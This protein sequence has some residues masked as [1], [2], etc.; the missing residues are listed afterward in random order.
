MKRIFQLVVIGFS[1]MFSALAQHPFFYAI[2]EQQGLP[3]REVYQLAQDS[4]GYLWIGTDAGLFRYDGKHFKPFKSAFQNSR[5][6]SNLIVAGDGKLWCQNFSGQIFTV[7]ADSLKLGID[8]SGKQTNYSIYNVSD[9]C[10]L[11]FTSDTGIY[12]LKNG[13]P[14]LASNLLEQKTNSRPCMFSDLKMIGSKIFFCESTML[15]YVDDGKIKLLNATNQPKRLQDVYR[16]TFI[17][18]INS[19]VILLA[20][21]EQV[22]SIWEVKNDS[23]LWL[24]DLPKSLG[25][26]FALH[27]DGKGKVWVGGSNGALCL[28]ENFEEV[29]GGQLFFQGVSISDVVVDREKNYWFSSLQEGIFVVPNLDVVVYTK[30]NSSL[31]DSRLKRLQA[32]ANHLF[33]GYQNG[34]LGKMNFKGDKIQHI[35]FSNSGVEIQE[36]SC[37]EDCAKLFIGQNNS[38]LLDAATMQEKRIPDDINLKSISHLS[39]D[40]FFL[41]SVNEGYIAKFSG[42][43]KR[44]ATLRVKRVRTSFYNNVKRELLVGYSDGVF[45]YAN[46]EERELQYKGKP[47]FATDMAQDADGAIWISTVNTG[48]VKYFQNDIVGQLN[49]EIG[50]T[51]GFVKRLEAD[52][53]NLWMVADKR[54]IRFDVSSGTY[55]WFDKYAGLP[56]QEISDLKIANG[57]VFLATPKG[58]V[59]FPAKMNPRNEVAPNVAIAAFSVRER[60]TTLKNS[61]TLPYQQ[62][63]IRIDFSSAS[64][65]SQG[66]FTFRYR[67]MDLDSNFIAVSADNSFVRFAS[68]PAGDYLFEVYAVNEGGVMSEKPAVINISILPPFWQRW[69]FYTLCGVA[70]AGVISLIFGLRIRQI[71]RRNELEKKVIASKLSA[72]KAQMNPHFMFNALSSIQ[73]LIL[74]QNTLKAQT[75]LGKFSDLTRKVLEA[76]DSE[77]ITLEKEMDMLRLYLDLESLRF[78]SSLKYE[79]QA[80]GIDDADELKIPSMIIQPIVENALKHGL[81]HKDGDKFLSVVFSKTGE[82][83]MCVVED[84]GIGRKA[85]AIINQRR[86]SHQSFATKATA[87]RLQLLR[88]FYGMEIEM[89]IEDRGEAAGET[90]TKVAIKMKTNY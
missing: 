71:N 12:I 40:T 72:L 2:A 39:K 63:S 52:G 28:D 82:D 31:A 59:A 53:S 67:M 55:H 17:Y 58:L 3:S 8:R 24:C 78:E 87:E 22:N 90:G 9:R 5:G 10:E 43:F 54:V 1:L 68:L 81:L 38:W 37:A 41:G 84:N 61:Y 42:T 73:D 6:I 85:S 89:T 45:V 4:F 70:F 36:I 26:V 46:G 27:P 14:E 65:R 34:A 57:K 69:W 29:F 66:D 19:R 48:V 56:T 88:E 35:T 11:Q 86:K 74:Q 25:R 7:Q 62:N 33:I 50:I 20:H 23:L 16:Q 80:H 44:I 13:K 60:D 49:E 64:F 77:F 18:N 21:G 79:L 32:S 15:G 75:Y 30:Q 47:I 76:S 51:D 83:L